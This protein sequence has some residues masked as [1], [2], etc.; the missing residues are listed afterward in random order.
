MCMKIELADTDGAIGREL[1]GIVHTT[2]SYHRMAIRL[3]EI[4]SQ[5]N[6]NVSKLPHL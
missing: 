4:D 1:D 3:R 2:G 5:C 6:F